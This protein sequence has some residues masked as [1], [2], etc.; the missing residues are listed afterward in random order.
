MWNARER[1]T[2][3]E[4]HPFI[5]LYFDVSLLVSPSHGRISRPSDG[6]MKSCVPYMPD[7]DRGRTG[8]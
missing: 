5:G 3:D 2:V 1:P 7:T 6:H 4:K 8:S